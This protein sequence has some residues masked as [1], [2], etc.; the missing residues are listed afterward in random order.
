MSVSMDSTSTKNYAGVDTEELNDIE[1]H[2]QASINIYRLNDK[3]VGVLKSLWTNRQLSA[4][5]INQSMI[6]P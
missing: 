3:N 6:K 1:N 2:F 5:T 4:L